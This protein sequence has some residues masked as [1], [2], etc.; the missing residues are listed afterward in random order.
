MSEKKKILL[1]DDDPDLLEESKIMIESRGYT[2]VTA[3]DS[4]SAWKKFQQEKPYAA[5]IDLIME[6]HDS[7]FV[8]CHKIKNSEYG[9]NIPVFLLTSATY[10]TGFKFSSSTSEEKE[11]IKCDE[12]INKPIP[13]DDLIS[14]IE[15]YY[16]SPEK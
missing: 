4:N 10:V 13:A 3:E 2:V 8:L 5:V 6:E 11:W 7:G 16:H 12:I 9:K 15:N 14:K 1:V